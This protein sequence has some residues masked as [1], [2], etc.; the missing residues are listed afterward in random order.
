MTK[1]K[2]NTTYEDF[3]SRV[4][5]P[6]AMPS[7]FCVASSISNGSGEG[8]ACTSNTSMLAAALL[9]SH[10]HSHKV[11]HKPEQKFRGKGTLKMHPM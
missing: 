7:P 2:D 3:I 9:D 1:H 4:Y 11:S 6:I 5:S 8:S 10:G